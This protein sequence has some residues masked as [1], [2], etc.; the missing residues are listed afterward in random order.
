MLFK[1]CLCKQCLIFVFSLIVETTRGLKWNQKPNTMSPHQLPRGTSWRLGPHASRPFP[2]GAWLTTVTD[3]RQSCP[4]S[5]GR[6]GSWCGRGPRLPNFWQWREGSQRRSTKAQLLVGWGLG[7]N[8]TKTN[9]RTVAKSIGTLQTHISSQ[10]MS[11]YRCEVGKAQ[12]PGSPA[13]LLGGFA[14]FCSS[15][16]LRLPG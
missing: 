9:K 10:E 4:M 3:V 5:S 11:I 12:F 1:Y 2:Q 15:H 7:L 16:A 14:V 13:E 6:P 8:K